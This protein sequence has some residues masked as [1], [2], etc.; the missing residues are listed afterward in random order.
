MQYDAS[1]KQHWLK[2]AELSFRASIEMEKKPILPT[3][4]PDKLKE[5]EWWKKRAEQS[6]KTST[7]APSKTPSS[8]T[9]AAAA[10]LK[11]PAAA[12]GT[13]KQRP[14]ATKQLPAAR[15]PPAAAGRGKTSGAPPSSTRTQPGGSGRVA[16]GASKAAIAKVPSKPSSVQKPTGARTG[17]TTSGKSVAT[18]GDLKAGANGS[19]ANVAQNSTAAAT[20]STATS[21][22]A[23]KGSTESD[24]NKEVEMN[25]SSYQPRLGLAR[26][27]AKT[28]DTKKLEEA[29]TF[30]KEVMRMS[31]DIHDAYIELGE[32]LA[33]TDPEGA[34][35]V[36]AKFPFSNPPTFDD[37]FL[38]GEITR[39]LMKSESYDNPR[40]ASSM[41]ATGKALGIGAL[42]KEVTILEGKFKSNL[43][44]SIYAG[45]HDKPIDDPELQAFFKFKCWL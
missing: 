31:P 39:L 40:L 5:E 10:A 17:S 29:H 37:A 27:L 44:K 33:K 16:A 41:I 8:S 28:S 35:E 12:V 9:V 3:V 4:I 2:D 36:Y 34:V 6:A 43:L 32:M 21:A 30:Y 26:T 19:K 11:K 24:K 42:E 15:Q 38:H 14:S 20:I 23:D 25:K 45:V 13:G 22:P 1:N 7:S 18:L